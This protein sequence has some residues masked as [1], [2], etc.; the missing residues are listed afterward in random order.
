MIDQCLFCGG[1]RSAPDHLRYC[2]GRQGGREDTPGKA[3]DVPWQEGKTKTTTEAMVLL[4]RTRRALIDAG[5]EVA[6]R[7]TANGGT[8][9]TCDVKRVMIAEGTYSDAVP[10]YWLGAVFRGREWTWTGE[11]ALPDVDSGAAHAWR[12]MRVWT[13]KST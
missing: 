4:L 10:G 7:L 8:A 3:C 1:D 2:D 12:P 11:W 6:R 13:Q 9:T 5:R